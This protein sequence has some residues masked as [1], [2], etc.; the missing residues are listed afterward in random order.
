MGYYWYF[1]LNRL[2]KSS[3]IRF[4]AGQRSRCRCVKAELVL[5]SL[6]K[7]K[8]AL[9]FCHLESLS[10]NHAGICGVV[11]T[12]TRRLFMQVVTIVQGAASLCRRQPAARGFDVEEPFLGS[13]WIVWGG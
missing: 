2:L 4:A 3:D 7:L 5:S 8:Y 10:N 6:F 9:L 13:E 12:A 1:S 11:H